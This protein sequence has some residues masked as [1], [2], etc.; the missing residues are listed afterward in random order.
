MF[1]GTRC[2]G[3]WPHTRQWGEGKQQKHHH[4]LR[5]W[6]LEAG[7]WRKRHGSGMLEQGCPS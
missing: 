4:H 3:P 5:G 7:V 2:L 6:G 1:G